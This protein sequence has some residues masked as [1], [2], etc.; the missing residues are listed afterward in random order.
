MEFATPQVRYGKQHPEAI[1]E[2]SAMASVEP[3]EPTYVP[4]LPL[5]LLSGE[6]GLPDPRTPWERHAEGALSAAQLETVVYAGQRHAQSNADGMRCGFL[7]GDGT[8]VGKGRQIAAIILDN[9]GA[10]RLRHIWCSISTALLF[11]SE[12][13]FV[14]LGRSNVSLYALHKMP[15]G[16]LPLDVDDGVMFCTYQVSARMPPH[17]ATMHARSRARTHIRNA[18]LLACHAASGL[19]W[20]QTLTHRHNYFS[21]RSLSSPE[22]SRGPHGLTS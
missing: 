11:D 7:V 20:T 12:R 10:G 14:D 18:H 16:E 21:C 22:T 9:M 17:I 15:Y 8:G 4:T 1:V 3:P 13:D 2:S 19:H 6:R 5:S